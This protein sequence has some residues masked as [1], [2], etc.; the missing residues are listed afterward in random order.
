MRLRPIIPGW[1]LRWFCLVTAV[2]NITG[3]VFL[4]L[5]YRPL[6][7]WLDIPLPRDLHL[8]TLECVL[9]FTMGVVALITYVRP[10]RLVLIV[11]IVG[12]SL[13]AGIT[14]YFWAIHALSSWFMIFVVWDV[15]FVGIFFL[16]WIQ[17]AAPRLFELSHSVFAGLD[18]RHDGRRA[19]VLA[20]SLTGNTRQAAARLTRGLERSGYEVDVEEVVPEERVFHQPFTFGRFLGTVIRAMFRRGAKFRPIKADRRRD[21]DL[22]VVTAPTWMLGL[23]APMESLLADDDHRDLFKGRDVAA[24]VVCRGAWQRSQA[25]MVYRLERA[26]ANV[27]TARG[28]SHQGWEPARLMLLW[29]RLITKRTRLFGVDYGLSAETLNEVEQ[30]GVD[31]AHRVRNRPHWTLLPEARHA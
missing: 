8:F 19:L 5:F 22:V 16:Y 31:L 10:D 30:L 18:T 15:V 6:F 28:Y 12:K 17:L 24:V 11:G 1:L 25:M 4:L 9:S 3:N 7:G 13:Y 27:V 2:A 20:L 29:W 26:G 14:Y 21:W 23:A